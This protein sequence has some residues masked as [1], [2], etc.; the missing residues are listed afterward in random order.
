MVGGCPNIQKWGAPLLFAF[1]I[2]PAGGGFF[3]PTVFFLLARHA[4]GYSNFQPTCTTPE[5]PVNFVASAGVRGTFDILWSCVFTILACTWTI[6]HLNIPEQRDRSKETSKRR[7][8]PVWYDA[9]WAIKRFWTGF[10]WMIA[11]ILAP[12]MILGKASGTSW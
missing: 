6:Q 12:E 5:T 2:V 10:K 7:G 1:F 11:T 8:A 4:R 3:L 9:V